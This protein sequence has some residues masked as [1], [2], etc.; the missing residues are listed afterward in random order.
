[1]SFN[2]SDIS[3]RTPLDFGEKSTHQRQAN[4][5]G[6]SVRWIEA[7]SPAAEAG[8]RPGDLILSI[9]GRLIMDVLDYRY[10]SDDPMLS[11][12]LLRGT[13]RV[14]VEIEKLP[15]TDLGLQFEQNL[16]DSIHV[17]NNRCVFCF[18]H[19][20]PKRMRRSLYLKDDDF[21]LSFLHGNYITLT[22]LSQGEYNRIK[23]QCLSPLYV[24]VHATDP[25]I[26]GQL[27]GKK[28]S[29]PILPQLDDL[30]RSRIDIHAQIVL[31]PGIND[32]GVLEATLDDLAA[33][34]PS[35]LIAE[36]H[37][38]P[39]R[40]EFRP[41]N[42]SHGVLSVA[43]VPVGL[44]KFREKLPK[45]KAATTDYARR[46]IR[47][48][49]TRQ[50]KYL[51]ELGTRFVWLSDEWYLM[52]EKSVPG[53]RHYERFP[54]YEDGVGTMRLFK[55]RQRALA[56]RLPD[57]LANSYRATVVTGELAAPVLADFI[58][59]LNGIR[60][61]HLNLCVI[62]N[63]FFG[64][65]INVTGLLTA[66]DILAQL[67]RFPALDEVIIPAVCLRDER[68]FLDDVTVP[69]LSRSLGKPVRVVGISPYDLAAELGLITRRSMHHPGREWLIEAAESERAMD[70]TAE[71]TTAAAAW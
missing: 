18:I 6:L 22:N 8:L 23:E 51:R 71:E 57:K 66:T 56:R 40:N 55:E 7:D 25:A 61:L 2:W 29:A 52:A 32:G 4:I 46:M 69:A 67:Q 1:M 11:I 35:L 58:G 16:A 9:N 20:M 54:Q 37:G 24:S 47:N 42:T 60:G 15:G 3:S 33:R 30:S 43:I 53:I 28:G 65:G 17:C 68:L 27:L 21:R 12:Q 49:H 26:R 14:T 5:S 13:N 38:S 39:D 10:Y 50:V 64:G 48:V 63:D 31:C 59:Q 45:L 41:Y 62:K 34:H 36:S 70:P 19:Q 44:T